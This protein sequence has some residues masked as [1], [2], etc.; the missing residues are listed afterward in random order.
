MGQVLKTP[1]E[2]RK[3]LKGTKNRIK[4]DDAYAAKAGV[5]VLPDIKAYKEGAV[6]A[7]EWVLGKRG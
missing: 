7:L 5:W 4:E 1:T 6:W 2:I 3:Q